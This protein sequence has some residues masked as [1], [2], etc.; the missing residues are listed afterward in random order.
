MIFMGYPN[1]C[2]PVNKKTTRL[3]FTDA[4][5]YNAQLKGN[6]RRGRGWG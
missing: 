3:R 4:D 2:A 6:I 1:N 5:D